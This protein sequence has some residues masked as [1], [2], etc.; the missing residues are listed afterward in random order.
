MTTNPPTPTPETEPGPVIVE[1][2][3]IMPPA[4]FPRLPE[5]LAALWQ[6]MRTLPLSDLQHDWFGYYL[7]RPD[8]VEHVSRTLECD[9]KLTLSFSLRDSPEQHLL[10]VRLAPP[11]TPPLP[12]TTS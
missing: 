7:T 2:T 11:R 12:T 3:G 1:L 5:A 9:G 6:S 8:A 4:T 10:R